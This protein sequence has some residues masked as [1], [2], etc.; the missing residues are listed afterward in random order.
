MCLW[1]FLV[2][3][4]LYVICFC[5]DKLI[6]LFYMLGIKYRKLI[7]K[8]KGMGERWLFYRDILFFS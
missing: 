3:F 2:L 4:F 1:D 6:I 7:R 5:W 8:G